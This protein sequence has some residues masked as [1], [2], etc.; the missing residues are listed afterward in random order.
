[1]DGTVVEEWTEEQKAYFE[2]LPTDQQ[3]D[4]IRR[5]MNQAAI[6]QKEWAGSPLP[7]DNLPLVLEPRYPFQALDG[8]VLGE[9][10]DTPGLWKVY[11]MI[12][13]H[14][15]YRPGDRI[16]NS[17]FL[18]KR[19]QTIYV[20]GDDSRRY[21]VPVPILGGERL[22]YLINTALASQCY[23]L[24]A[25]LKAQEKLQKHV[26]PHL[27]KT[28]ICTGMLVETSKRSKMTYI[29]RRLRPTIALRSSKDGQ[30]MMIRSVL[31]LHPIGYY[32]GSYAGA[33]VPTD[34]VLAHLLMMRACEEKFWAKANH[35]P[36][37]EV[38]AGI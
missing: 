34:D 28:Y 18:T 20:C 35:H 25:E 24:E 38:T 12:G 5:A 37:Y 16:I 26:P 4:L 3:W 17:F 19:W 7:H 1:M 13:C 32:H 11:G 27:F 10:H 2:S 23:S 36:H 8:M 9:E 33:M 29:F 31:C 30:N 14:P 6:D 15:K 21:A 22:E